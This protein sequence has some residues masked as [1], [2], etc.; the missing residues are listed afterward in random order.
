MSIYNPYTDGCIDC[1]GRRIENENPYFFDKDRIFDPTNNPRYA[2]D[3]GLP[4]L[5]TMTNSPL[6][7]THLHYGPGFGGKHTHQGLKCAEQNTVVMEVGGR[8]R[9]DCRWLLKA[10]T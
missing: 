9:Y 6:G 7:I 1:T 3:L 4:S 8:E 2:N 5:L 10:P